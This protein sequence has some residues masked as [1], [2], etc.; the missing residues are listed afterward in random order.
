MLRRTQISLAVVFCFVVGLALIACTPNSQNS[1]GT[2]AT[3]TADWSIDGDCITCH[4]STEDKNGVLGSL[5]LMHAQNDCTSCHADG[6]GELSGAHANATGVSN[7]TKLKVT[8]VKNEQCLSCHSLETIKKVT[9][10]W[11]GKEE[12]NPHNSM[13]GVAVTCTDCHATH[14][15]S[16]MACN[17]CHGWKLPDNWIQPPTY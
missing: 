13:H 4:A 2:G 14:E 16:T 10:L 11:G 8:T 7:A 17:E 12:V 9:E 1:S 6:D 3:T 5:S 15:S